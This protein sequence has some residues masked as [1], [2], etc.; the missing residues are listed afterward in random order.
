MNISPETLLVYAVTDR[1]WLNGRTVA[2]Q[3]E[4]AVIGGATFIQLREKHLPYEEFLAEA[5]Q[6]KKITDCYSTP[7]VINDQVDIAIACDADGVHIGQE[8]LPV[9][10]VR[11]L[12]GPYKILGVSA[13]TVEQALEAEKAGADYLGV[14]AMFPTSTKQDA[15]NVNLEILKSI[16]EAVSIPV[17]AIGGITEQNVS[18]LSGSGI[19]GVA[20]ISALFA[21]K[22]IK[23]ATRRL[24]KL[25]KQMVEA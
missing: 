24:V 10:S 19:A 13:Q 3:V 15:E 12:I 16:C 23:E 6:V 8:D 9:S 22:D 11:K 4:E 20:V 2:Q 14:G 7:F 18:Q 25:S 21:Q 17:V 1:T 5:I